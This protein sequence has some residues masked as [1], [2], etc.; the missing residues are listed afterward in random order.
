MSGDQFE[1]GGEIAWRPSREYVERSRLTQFMH[2][3]GLPDYQALLDRSTTEL[4]WFWDAVIEDLGIQ[5]YEP[6]RQVIDTSAGIPWT[7]WCVGGRLNI[8][9]NCLDKWQGTPT[10]AQPALHWEG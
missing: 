8:V 1:F 3:Y 7:R 5:F 2:R 10:A 4:A 9:H 6:Y